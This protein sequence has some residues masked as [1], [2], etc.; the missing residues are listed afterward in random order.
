MITDVGIAWCAPNQAPVASVGFGT[1]IERGMKADGIGWWVSLNAFFFCFSGNFGKEW[2]AA[3][4]VVFTSG[5]SLPFASLTSAVASKQRLAGY[6]LLWSSSF[7]NGWLDTWPS[8]KH[9]KGRTQTGE[10]IQTMYKQ[11]SWL[12]SPL[13]W[14]REIHKNAISK[15]LPLE[16]SH[17]VVIFVGSCGFS[18]KQVRGHESR[19]NLKLRC[20]G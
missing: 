18:G 2:Q 5:P 1:K 19:R 17:L 13:L 3:I 7:G 6:V 14:R 11:T 10:S 9:L 12:L 20:G 4:Y 16:N 8:H 15:W